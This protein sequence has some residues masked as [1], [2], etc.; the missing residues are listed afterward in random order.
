MPSAQAN[1]EKKE[2]TMNFRG[3]REEPLPNADDLEPSEQAEDEADID[4]RREDLDTYPESTT[5]FNKW[6]VDINPKLRA[7][8]AQLNK[9]LVVSNLEPDEIDMTEAKLDLSY[10]CARKGYA[11]A[12]SFFLFKSGI[13]L[14]LNRSKKGF[15]IRQLGTIRQEKDITRNMPENR[16][17]K[18]IFGR[19]G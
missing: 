8:F 17:K 4:M 15:Q 5:E 7:E 6:L 19:F 12:S 9:E 2:K 18:G 10:Q 16:R 11:S 14:S 13:V 1:S 3:K